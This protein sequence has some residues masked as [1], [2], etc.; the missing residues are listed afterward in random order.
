MFHQAFNWTLWLCWRCIRSNW[1]EL[2]LSDR[3]YAFSFE[4]TVLAHCFRFQCCHLILSSADSKA[5][6]I[7]LMSHFMR[8]NIARQRQQWHTLL[9][10]DF[11]YSA[12][13]R[14]ENC[15]WNHFLS[16]IETI[17][18]F[19]SCFWGCH[20]V[21]VSLSCL[22]HPSAF[23]FYYMLSLAPFPSSLSLSRSLPLPLPLSLLS[24]PLYLCLCV[25]RYLPFLSKRRVS[26][27]SRGFFF[28]STLSVPACC[29]LVR[30]C[31]EP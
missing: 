4:V 21:M 25:A 23:P 7:K 14:V 22:L 30:L 29:F 5:N 13:R 20:C 8:C 3:F 15:I 1:F 2:I 12:W 11:I 6:L 9:F 26:H 10:N 24:L 27:F 16:K 31:T 19:R 28:S 17:N 18:Y